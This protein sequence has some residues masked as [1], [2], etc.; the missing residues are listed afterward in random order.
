MYVQVSST[1][2]SGRSATSTLPQVIVANPVFGAEELVGLLSHQIGLDP[3]QPPMAFHQLF[4]SQPTSARERTQFSDL[5]AVTRHVV[6]LPRLNGIHDSG[7]VVAELALADHSHDHS[8]AP[9]SPRC[10]TSRDRLVACTKCAVLHHVEIWVPDLRRA[11][12]SWGWLLGELGCVP[13]QE[14]G[15]GRSWRHNGTYLVFE[16]SPALTG[17]HDRCR[18]G[19]NHLA[20]AVGD[21]EAVDRLTTQAREH[22]WD[23][24]FAD[25]HPFAGGAEHYAAYLVNQDGFEVELVAS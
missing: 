23:L 5:N 15:A 20:F 18:A 12:E 24:L 21:R 6:S 22:G 14:W 1:P 3:R 25:R 2:D 9:R 11:V 4:G 19:L 7:G 13:Y 16:Q 8:V 17:P 10:Y